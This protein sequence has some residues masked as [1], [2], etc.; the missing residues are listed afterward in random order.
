[1]CVD[2]GVVGSSVKGAVMSMKRDC[3]K[4]AG[5]AAAV[6]ILVAAVATFTPIKPARAMGPGVGGVTSYNPGGGASLS[7]TNTWTGAQTIQPSTDVVALTVTG[8]SGGTSDAL[9]VKSSNAGFKALSVDSGGVLQFFRTSDGN[10]AGSIYGDGGSSLNIHSA[11]GAIVFRDSAYFQ[12]LDQAYNNIYVAGWGRPAIYASGRQ[13]AVSAAAASSIATF[14]PVADGTFLVS[15][16]VL[17]TT[18]GSIA[19]TMTCTYT[20]EGNTSRT[21]TMPFINIAGTAL[22]A[23]AFANGAVPYEGIPIKIRVKGG[24]AITVQT[25]GTFTGSVYNCEADI[26]Q[27]R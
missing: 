25:A 19:A 7:G 14:T 17:V 18:A 21:Q 27:V 22:T 2:D 9:Q 8:K 11:T 5:V 10:S 12:A 13:A 23:I 24:T 16:N 6:L 15:G 20:D 1:M 3:L 4:L 26:V